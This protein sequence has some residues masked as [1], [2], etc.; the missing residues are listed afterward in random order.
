MSIDC[1]LL[2][3]ELQTRKE[4][5]DKERQDYAE[6]MK[7]KTEKLAKRRPKGVGEMT[8]NNN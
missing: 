5:E 3:F 7:R 2:T 1:Y 4:E 6:K 8:R